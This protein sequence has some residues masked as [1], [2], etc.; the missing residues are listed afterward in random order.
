LFIFKDFGF[1]KDYPKEMAEDDCL[2]EDLRKALNSR[3]LE[4]PKVDELLKDRIK[5]GRGGCL[6]VGF[7]KK[8]T[9]MCAFFESSA[10]LDYWINREYCYVFFFSFLFTQSTFIYFC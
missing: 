2:K 5:K 6:K 8:T 1:V 7:K 3:M 10:T 4:D 9:N